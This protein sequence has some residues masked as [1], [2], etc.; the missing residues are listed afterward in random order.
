MFDVYKPGSV[1][2]RKARNFPQVMHHLA[3][4]S[5]TPPTP[6]ELREAEAQARAAGSA[7][8]VM[9]AGVDNTI[10]FFFQVRGADLLPLV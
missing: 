1:V 3:L 4:C 2:G 10:V 8:P 5:A 7:A 6:R 9:W